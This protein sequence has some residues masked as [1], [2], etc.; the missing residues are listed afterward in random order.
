MLIMRQQMTQLLQ[1]LGKLEINL[2]LGALIAS[3]CGG[4]IGDF[5]A[6]DQNSSDL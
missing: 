2:A 4:F 6:R 1:L 5:V 3:D